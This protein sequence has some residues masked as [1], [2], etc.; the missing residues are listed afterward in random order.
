MTLILLLHILFASTFTSGK[1]LSSQTS[2]IFLTGLR[3][4]LGGIIVLIYLLIK[5]R[6]REIVFD[7]A[8]WKSFAQ[9]LLFGVYANYILRFW[10]LAYLPSSKAC[11]LFNIQP[12]LSSLYVYLLYNEKLSFNRWVGLLVGFL[13]MIP[14]LISNSSSELAPSTFLFFSLPELAT[15]VSAG[16]HSYSWIIVQYLVKT[17]K[18]DPTFITGTTMTLGGLLALATAWIVGDLPPLNKSSEFLF[19]LLYVV[20]VSNVFC[21]NLYGHLLKIYSATLMAFASFLTPIFAG[22]LGAVF[23]KETITWHFYIST[24]VVCMGLYIFY[25]DELVMHSNKR[26]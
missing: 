22:I 25:S 19:L 18:Y 9:I 6:K 5:N 23:L 1:F 3:M 21:H 26:T 12:F 20:L 14:I 17:K 2:P 8:D 16:M 13:G 24:I 7:W 11:F 4:F 10:A 15:L